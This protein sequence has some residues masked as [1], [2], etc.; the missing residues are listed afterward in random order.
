[1]LVRRGIVDLAV[2]FVEE[3]E[4]E[5][6]KALLDQINVPEIQLIKLFL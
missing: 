4:L 1:M 3:L 6:V 5:E 2:F